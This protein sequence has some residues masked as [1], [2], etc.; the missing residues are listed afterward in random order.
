MKVIV[1]GGRDFVNY[2][3]MREKLDFLLKNYA[4]DIVIVCGEAL[5][6]DSLGKFY[7]QRKGY[8]V[9]SYPADW[10]KYGKSAGIRRNKQMAEVADALVA[11]WDGKSRGTKNMIEQ[12]RRLKKPVKIV[13]YNQ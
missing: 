12:M 3:L 8:N 2:D 9:L 5:G 1:A 13:Y 4:Q 11:F 7:A 10:N 6:A